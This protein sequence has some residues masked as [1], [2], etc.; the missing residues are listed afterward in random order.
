MLNY[1]KDVTKL[2]I[3]IDLK[4]LYV[5]LDDVSVDVKSVKEGICRLL[6]QNQLKHTK[7]LSELL[8]QKMSILQYSDIVYKKK[9]TYDVY[10]KNFEALLEQLLAKEKII[11]DKIDVMKKSEAEYMGMKGLHDDI[12]RSHILGQFD[13]ELNDINQTK[14]EIVKNILTLRSEQDNLTLNMDKILFDN[15]VMI[16]EIS[17]NFSKLKYLT[18]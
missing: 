7:I 6:N 4:S 3:Y 16:N 13:V 11:L 1:P 15:T 12:E 8:E 2:D 14:K 9:E 18:T 10:I 5:K 17:K